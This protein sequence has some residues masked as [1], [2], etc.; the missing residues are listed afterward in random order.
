MHFFSSPKQLEYLIAAKLSQVIK[1]VKTRWN[2]SFYSWQRLLLLKRALTFLPSK[3]K[4]DHVKENTNDG[5]R[6]ER[7]MLTEG[8]WQLME[9][10]VEFLKRFEEITRLL[11]GSKYVTLSLVYPLI[12]SLKNYIKDMLEI[13]QKDSNYNENTNEIL[14]DDN[15]QDEILEEF[16]EIPDSEVADIIAINEKGTKKNFNISTPIETKGLIVL[17]LEALDGSLKKYYNKDKTLMNSILE[18]EESEG[19]KENEV[20]VYLKLK[21]SKNVNPLSWWKVNEK[22]FPFLSKVSKEYFGIAATSVPSERL[23]SDVGNLITTKRSS[24]KPEKVEKLIFLKRNAS[25]F[26]N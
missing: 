8:E 23:F 25:L 20:D 17:F 10:L 13:Y 21:S 9:N 2:S 6:L 5:K 4:A 3:L 16:E 24:L 15:V 26:D 19:E 22:K 18:E 11:G 12:F 14:S 1:D 7:I